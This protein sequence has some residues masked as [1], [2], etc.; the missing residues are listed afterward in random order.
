MRFIPIF[1]LA[2]TAIFGVFSCS[3]D[4]DLTAEPKDI[5]VVYGVL[6]PNDS[7]Q[8]VRVSKAFLVDGNALE[9][10]KDSDLSAKNIKVELWNSRGK[11]SHTATALVIQKDSGT[12]YRGETVYRFRTPNT[13]P[14]REE[15]TYTLRITRADQPN[16]LI[17]AHATIPST[18]TITSPG[19]T[20]CGNVGANPPQAFWEQVPIESQVNLTFRKKVGYGYELRAGLAYRQLDGTPQLATWYSNKVS[21]SQ[22]C[23]GSPSAVCYDISGNFILSSFL[24][25]MQASGGTAWKYNDSTSCAPEPSLSR[26]FWFEATAIDTAYSKYL[27]VNAPQFTDLN[28]VRPEF[29]NITINAPKSAAYGIF[30]AINTYRRY[31]ALTPCGKYL[32]RLN[33]AAKPEGKCSL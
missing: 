14:L 22:N 5:W 32:L 10:A 1:L 4:V 7:L 29:T 9:V 16:F 33:N 31:C 26:A 11:L 13:N 3:T 12:F 6:N 15:N 25:Q 18:P 30:G 21:L 8:Y 27:V 24:S 17:T 28:D 2:L 19:S 20:S 23:L